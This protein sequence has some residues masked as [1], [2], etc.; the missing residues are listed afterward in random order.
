[1]AVETP[2]WKY[3]LEGDKQTAS[4]M[5]QLAQAVIANANEL[6]NAKDGVANVSNDVS[7]LENRLTTIEESV[8]NLADDDDLENT[9]I[10]GEPVIRE[11]TTKTYAPQTFVLITTFPSK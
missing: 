6:S 5:N 1:M 2:T 4:E 3:K 9:I 10:N 8:A 7:F 11:K